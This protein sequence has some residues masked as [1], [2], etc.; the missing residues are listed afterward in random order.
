LTRYRKLLEDKPLKVLLVA[1]PRLVYEEAA[2]LIAA[3]QS[4]GAETIHL[5]ETPVVRVKPE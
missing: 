1:D 2:R 3:A 5:A 4:A